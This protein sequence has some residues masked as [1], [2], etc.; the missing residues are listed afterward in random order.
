MDYTA[1]LMVLG[2]T[3][4]LDTAGIREK[5]HICNILMRKYI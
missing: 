3:D 2:G 1:H 4:G 5:R